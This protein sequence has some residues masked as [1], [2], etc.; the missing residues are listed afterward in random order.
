[1]GSKRLHKNSKHPSFKVFGHYIHALI[2]NRLSKR[3]K[4]Y[5]Q[6]QKC[7]KYKTNARIS[8]FAKM[9]ITNAEE[10]MA[11][12]D[13][14]TNAL[15]EQKEVYQPRQYQE[16]RDR[17]NKERKRLN[18]QNVE[19]TAN[20]SGVNKRTVNTQLVGRTLHEKDENAL[21]T[22]TADATLNT[23]SMA[24]GKSAERK[25]GFC[26]KIGLNMKRCSRCKKVHYC[27]V[28]CQRSH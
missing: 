27:T 21:I 14:T 2:L 20:L 26:T 17:F 23:V 5:I 25:C 1:M 15:N 9:V 8:Y 12:M 18:A 10:M 28:D 22:I 19:K 16:C 13:I 24:I 7:V 11:T 3:A 4:S 6:Y